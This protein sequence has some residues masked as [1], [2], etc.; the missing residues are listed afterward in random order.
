MAN[1]STYGWQKKHEYEGEVVDLS[2]SSKADDYW[3][4]ELGGT[5]GNFDLAANY[6]HV[7]DENAMGLKG[8]NKIW[9]AAATYNSGKF[10]LGAMYLQGDDDLLTGAAKNY[11]DDGFVVSMGWA[12][13]KK[14]EAGSWGLYGKYYDQS[15]V[16]TMAHTMNGAYYAFGNKG[17]KGYMV[18][19]NV[20]LAKNM[21]A[22]VEYYDLKN[23]EG[24]DDK[25]ARTLWSELAISF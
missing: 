9:T 23:K 18:G 14:S 20:T 25:H 5:V 22:S 7:N 12:G 19:G 2:K 8:D 16:T 11:D 21:V 6:L 1:E 13:A 24:N 3:M 4:A 10:S 17:F 15:A